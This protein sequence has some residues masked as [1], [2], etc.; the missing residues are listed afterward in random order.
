[1]R[2]FLAF[3][4]L[5]CVCTFGLFLHKKTLKKLVFYTNFLHFC[6]NAQTEINYF[7]KKLYEI[8]DNKSGS[9]D[10]LNVLNGFKNNETKNVLNQISYLSNDEK[11][12]LEKF[13]MVLGRKDVE[14]EKKQIEQE[15]FFLNEKIKELKSFG[16]KKSKLKFNLCIS[17][18][19]LLFIILI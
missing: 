9:E 15:I 6:E 18:G 3:C 7:H 8:I 11:S 19:V 17:F 1:M 14:S 12:E 2:I 13:F 16:L 4:V 5:L 10:F